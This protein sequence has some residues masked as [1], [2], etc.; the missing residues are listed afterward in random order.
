MWK[1]VLLVGAGGFIG[2]ISRYLLGGWAHALW[3]RAGF[4]IGTLLVNIAGCFCI[5]L[6]AGFIEHRQMFG[7]EARLFL[8]IGLL[9]GFTTFSTF[10]YETLGLM[11]GS[12]LLAAL[13][14]AV[15]HVAL[16]LLA[17]W[18]GHGLV[19]TAIGSR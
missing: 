15:G 19:T 7:P 17:A 5:G 8:L 12:A 10:A 2:S 14:N 9:G 18:G 6:L 11:R 4:P 13:L 1:E 16:G 3:P